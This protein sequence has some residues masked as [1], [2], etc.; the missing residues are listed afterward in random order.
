MERIKI[1]IVDDHKLVSKAIENMIS[2]NP[3]FEVVMNC[4]NG[5]DFLK[6]LDH[7]KT[8]PEV[9]LMDINMPRKNGIE[10][11]LELTKNYPDLK[12]IAL[13]MEDNEST[14]ISMLKAG[15]KGY[16][17]KDMSPDILFDAIN[18]VHEK[19]IFY[20]DIVTQSLL[21]IKTEEKINQ[22]INSSLKDRE[23]EFIK[24]ACSELTYKEIAE[25]MCVSPRTVD[26][27][28]DSIFAK[29][30]VKT[31]VGI[32]LFAIKHHMC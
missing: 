31:R 21:K 18:I 15:A 32:V 7:R 11:T 19:G 17:L 13:T 5:E 10:T 3:K 12:V 23:V 24:L 25:Q 22:E 28:R 20:T 29:L 4:F 27:Y 16:L 8:L 1:A 2:F 9:V 30:N 26:G 6:Q 14:I